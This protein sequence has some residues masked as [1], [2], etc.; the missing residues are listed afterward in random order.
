MG[1]DELQ[2][3]DRTRLVFVGKG[4]MVGG[5]TGVVVSLFRLFI[6]HFSTL[7]ENLYLMSQQQPIY[8]AFW[9]FLSMGV[10]IFVGWL[11]KTE[12]AIKGSGIPQVEGQLQDELDY[13]WFQVLWKKF[14]GGALSVGAGLFLGREGPSIQ[15]GATIGQGMADTQKVPKFE[16]KI[17]ISSGAS[18]GLAAA[19]NAPIAG[20]LFVIEEVHHTFSPLVWLTSFASAL[21]AN[22]VSLYVFGLRPVL[23]LGTLQDIPLRH[24]WLFIIFGLFLGLFARLY[25]YVLLGLPRIFYHLP[26]PSYFHGIVPFL[27]VIPI[28][29]FFPHLLGGGNQIITSIEHA[30]YSITL[31]IALFALRFLFSM[32]SYGSSLPGGIFLP[33]LTLGAIL[34]C[35]F[36]TIAVQYFGLDSIY[37]RNFI[38]VGMAG[39]FAAIG[40]AP[41]TAIILITEMVGSLHH[42]MATGLVSLVAYLVVDSLGGAPIYESL[43]ERLLKNKTNRITGKRQLIEIPIT[44]ESI[45]DGLAV[46]DFQWPKN[47]LLISLQRGTQAILTH[48]ETIMRSG[49]ILLIMTDSSEANELRK[50]LAIQINQTV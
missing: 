34:G 1:R 39:Y 24:Y 20:L 27:L 29:Y 8:L 40:K 43:L 21:T 15:L 16:R 26:L 17:L 23:Y 30:D 9:A 42:L 22:F 4:V 18:A 12:P 31:L 7:T 33:I 19:F 13:P 49:D 46:R 10:A 28:G 5:L 3:I 35:L 14:I 2:F 50:K 48:G 47:M 38:I 32:I 37:I 41:L 25:Q 6:E 11:I 36:A 45:L 44:A